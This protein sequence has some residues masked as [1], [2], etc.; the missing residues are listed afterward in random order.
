MDMDMVQIITVER[1][2]RLLKLWST[3]STNR[4]V[5]WRKIRGMGEAV[6]PPLFIWWNSN[7]MRLMD[8]LMIIISMAISSSIL[9]ATWTNSMGTAVTT[10]IFAM[11]IAHI[12]ANRMLL[13]SLKDTLTQISTN[14][15]NSQRHLAVIWVNSSN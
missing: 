7:Q 8:L 3:A 11:P 12:I 15:N 13:G 6:T 5:L 10:K 4:L 1:V 9:M 14:K 2:W